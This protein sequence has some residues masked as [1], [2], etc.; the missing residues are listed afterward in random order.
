VTRI[1][2][3]RTLKKKSGILLDVS[4]GGVPQANSVTFQE[5]D[6]DPLEVPF[7]LPDRSVHTAVVTHVLEYLEP[8]QWFAWWDELHRVMRPGGLVFMSGP[9]GGDE[10]QGWLSDPTHRTRVV[11]QSVAWLDP[12]TPFY[13]MHKT[14]GRETPKPW[15]PLTLARVPGTH[16]TTSYNFCLQSQVQE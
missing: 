5:L 4:L 13:T 12:R 6:A 10:S 2:T 14:V 7:P 15:H 3:K 16:G 11:E 9:Y 8:A 1:N